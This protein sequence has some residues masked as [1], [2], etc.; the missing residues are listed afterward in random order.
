VRGSKRERRPGVWE[1]RAYAG[2]DPVTGRHLSVSRTFHGGS[3]LADRALRAL[4]AEVEEGKVGG[5]TTTI[6]ALARAWL[7]ECERVGRSPTTLREYRRIVEQVVVPNL[8]ALRLEEVTPEH[9]DRLYGTLSAGGL[10]PASVQRVHAAIRGM[11]SLGVRWG[12]LASNPALR[13]V[14][15]AARRAP[16]SVPDPETVR[17]LLAAAAED[18]RDMA[19]LIW[20]A[21]VTGARRGELCGLR[22][23]D[24][25][26]EGGSLAIVR[27]E[28]AV[29][30]RRY[31]KDTKAHGTRIVALDEVSM[32][33]LE[34]HR[35]RHDAWASDLGVNV[36]ADTPILTYNLCQAIHPD[37]ASHYV[38]DLARRLGLDVHLHALRHFAA[39]QLVGA[40]VDVRTVAGRLGHAD[41]S[42]T[43]RVYA[44][45]LPERDRRAAQILGHA[46]APGVT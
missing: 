24:V 46:L 17:T 4:V 37:T 6:A 41:A 21:S 32:S 12:W 43:L 28:V 8:G 1:L 18:D 42:T 5:S 38:R 11:G 35:A 39:T 34:R 31:Q 29:G 25:D 36:T 16:M 45:A 40:G 2:R 27:S 13:A 19:V 9:L 20:L 26:W 10:A 33:L 22:W 7:A 3:R 15:P 23:G 30:G 14:P 44:H